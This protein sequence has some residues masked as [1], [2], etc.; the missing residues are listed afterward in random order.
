[1][2]ESPVTLA[3]LT[4]FVAGSTADSVP[5]SFV[6]HRSP[7]LSASASGFPPIGMRAT[8]APVAAPPV[9]IDRLHAKAMRPGRETHDVRRGAARDCGRIDAAPVAKLRR[10]ETGLA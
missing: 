8:S 7:K 10:W 4:A 2:S 5:S 6:T 9:W 1:M 3:P